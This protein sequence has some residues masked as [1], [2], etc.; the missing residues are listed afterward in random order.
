MRVASCRKFQ[1]LTLRF[2]TEDAKM[3]ISVQRLLVWMTHE[4]DTF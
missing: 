2:D 3:G 1:C 4:A